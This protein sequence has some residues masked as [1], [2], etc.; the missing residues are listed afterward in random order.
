[1]EN[2]IKE[3]QLFLFADRTSCETMRANQLRLWFSSVAYVL[4]STLRR[5]A[6][7]GTELAAA[8]CDTIRRKLFKIGAWVQVTVRKVWV[9]FSES[10][11]FRDL[12]AQACAGVAAYGARLALL[13]P[14]A[15]A[16]P[17][18]A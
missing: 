4:L 12:F 15:A 3:Q 8:Q 2:R 14:P 10:F 7:P 5:Q 9:K 16:R 17:P 18:P 11:P 6:L 1:M 13:D